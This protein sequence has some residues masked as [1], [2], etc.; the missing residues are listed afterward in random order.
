PKAD[1]EKM[2]IYQELA[3][4]FKSRV[5]LFEGTW[6]KYH[7]GTP[8]AASGADPAKYLKQAADA[9]EAVINSG[10]FGLD[11]Q[12]AESGYWKLFNQVDYSGSR[13]IMFWRKYD[14][15][16]GLTH[17]W[18]RY[19]TS[20][21]GFGVTKDL[22]DSY[23]CTDGSPITTSPLYTGDNTQDDIIKNRDPRLKQSI[24][25]SGAP[26]TVNGPSATDNRVYQYPT[27]NQAGESRSMTGFQLYKGHSA[28]Y[29][30]QY[31]GDIGTTG[32]IYM[33]YAEILLNYA[34]AKAEL[35]IFTQADADK[36]VNLLRTRVGMPVMN[37]ASITPDPSWPFPALSPV[38]NEVRRERRIELALEGFRFN[39]ICRWAA[40]GKLLK[41]WKPLGAKYKQWENVP[42]NP[43]IIV[44]TNLYVNADGYIEPFQKVAGLINGY[45]FNTTRDYLLP[46]P[47]QEVQQFNFTQNPGW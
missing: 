27:I 37:T 45:Q 20:G 28:E 3:Q 10:K 39:D 21:G 4:G 15:A 33:R 8:F 19:T 14:V 5:A 44:G 25:V 22:V 31:T 23:L 34:E 40:A 26:I 13:E 29:L 11:N 17:N 7:A 2:R 16:L 12:G 36:S 30:Q 35:G 46:I 41:G 43:R 32:T 9:A 1:A 42:Y 38:L 47:L 6:E 18:N 24:Y